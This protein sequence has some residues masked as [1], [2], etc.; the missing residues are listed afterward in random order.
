MLQTYDSKNLP[1][2]KPYN[3]GNDS[4]NGMG[5]LL[6]IFPVDIHSRMAYSMNNNL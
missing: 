4:L 1:A 6:D 5:D 3:G 2:F